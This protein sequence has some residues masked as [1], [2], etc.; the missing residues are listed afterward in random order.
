M[1]MFPLAAAERTWLNLLSY[2]DSGVVHPLGENAEGSQLLQ[3]LVLVFILCKRVYVGVADR[4][5]QTTGERGSS[6]VQAK[7]R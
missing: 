3:R 6:D 4:Y 1:N 2:V 7:L 5:V